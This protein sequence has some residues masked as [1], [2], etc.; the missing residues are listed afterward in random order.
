M[1]LMGGRIGRCW[2][3]TG[4]DPQMQRAIEAKRRRGEM[5]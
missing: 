3:G 1:R 4:A 5:Y 2:T